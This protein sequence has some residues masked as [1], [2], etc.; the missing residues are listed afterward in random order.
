MDYYERSNCRFCGSERLD[1]YLDL[2]DQPPSNS[3]VNPEEAHQ[4]RRY[5]LKVF[6]CRQC[7]LSQ[8]LGVVSASQTFDDYQYLSSTSKALIQHYQT[9]VDYLIGR[10]KPKESSC[11]LD[12]GCNDG[13]ML[14]RYPKSAGKTIGVE[15]SKVAAL[16]RQAGHQIYNEFF[17]SA[18]AKTIVAEHG[19]M[20]IVTAT[21][22]FAHID[23]IH[24]VVEGVRLLVGDEGVFV[25]EAP[26]VVDMVENNYFDTVYHEHLCYL[27]VTP[28]CRLMAMHGM[29]VFD[30]ERVAVGASGPAIRVFCRGSRAGEA[31]TTAVQGFLDFEARWGLL[32]LSPYNAFAKRLDGIRDGLLRL[33]R[34]LIASGAKIGAYGAPAKGN[35]LLNTFHLGPDLITEGV[36]ETNSVKQG[37][38]TPG[39]HLPIIS[40]AEFLKRRP[41]HALLLTWNYLEFFLKNS[42]YIEQGGR[43]IVPLPQPAIHPAT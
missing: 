1:L 23:E 34:G 28:L 12:I 37:K 25:I 13:I 41:S 26:Y 27:A 9:L 7:G 17:G 10:F 32:D 39:S 21:N 24:D 36:A 11:F 38:L 42:P 35:T 19:M 31:P 40:E 43:F 3:F 4:E 8:L 15:P 6:L 22:V 5:P 16:A 18:L 14:N 30:V 2:G 29:E 20:R 33:I